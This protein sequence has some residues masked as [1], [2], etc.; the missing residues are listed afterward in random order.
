MRR[1][2]KNNVSKLRNKCDSLLTPIIKKKC[3]KC[4]ACNNETQVAHH[5]I[6]KS[7]SLNLRYNFKNL[8]ALCHSCHARIHNRFGN[9]VVGALDVATII[10]KK[11]GQ[12]WK[13]EMDREGRKIIK[14][15][16]VFYNTTLERLQSML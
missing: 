7:R 10:I 4:E 3:P 13:E 8:V 15:D 12:E 5:W 2:G 14:G 6:E 1:I 11:R 9:S 16:I